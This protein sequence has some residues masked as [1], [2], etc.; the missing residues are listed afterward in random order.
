MHS[1]QVDQGCSGGAGWRSE[2]STRRLIITSSTQITSILVTE[3]QIDRTH[4]LSVEG[5]AG[6]SRVWCVSTRS[7]TELKTRRF[8][9]S[10][11][12][13]PLYPGFIPTSSVSFLLDLLRLLL[14]GL[15]SGL[16]NI[17]GLL[18]LDAFGAGRF[19]ILQCPKLVQDAYASYASDPKTVIDE[20][21]MSWSAF[22]VEL[23]IVWKSAFDKLLLQEAFGLGDRF[24]SNVSSATVVSYASKAQRP[25]TTHNQSLIVQKEA[26]QKSDFQ[27]KTLQ[28]SLCPSTFLFSIGQQEDYLK[29]GFEND[30]KRCN[31]CRGQEC[32]LFSSAGG[33]PYGINC[34]FLHTDTSSGDAP[35]GAD[36]AAVPLNKP[37]A[38]EST[39]AGS[40]K[41]DAVKQEPTALS[42]M[43]KL[44]LV[45]PDPNLTLEADQLLN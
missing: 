10:L 34:K 31:K 33:C 38:T 30:P 5:C 26:I 19:F 11:L 16:D 36:S 23:Q 20:L 2:I 42:A 1:E 14:R 43:I 18:D 27:D 39:H 37:N 8:C 6:V 32:H 15:G 45:Q 9:L 40:L 4:L 29:K 28:C 17:Q 22:R 44:T 13:C 25:P 12:P 35:A 41:Q 7:Y 21:N 3:L 24:V